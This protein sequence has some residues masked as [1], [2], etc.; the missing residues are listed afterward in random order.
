MP[1]RVALDGLR[2]LAERRHRDPARVL[3]EATELLARADDPGVEATLW[4]VK[5][6][7]LQELGRPNEAVASFRRS[8]GIDVGP[9]LEEGTALARASLAVSLLSV[10]ETAAA[11]REISRARAAAPPSVQWVVEMLHGLVLQRTGRLDA[12]L[13]TYRRSLPGLLAEGHLPYVARLLLNR[14]ALLA[15][16]GELEDALDD[17]TEAERISTE[18]GLPI[19]AAMAAHNGAFA[20]VRRGDLPDALAAFDRAERAYAVL[21]NPRYQ[22]AV[23]HADRCEALLVAGLVSEAR[24]AAT[25]AVRALE[26]TGDVANLTESRLLLARALLADGAYAEAITEATMAAR[27]FQASR[28]L[29]WAAQA[30]YVALQAEALASE[31]QRVPP[32][33]LLRRSRRIASELE[34]QGWPVEALHVRT[35]VGRIALALGRPT[36]ARAELA[37]A[38][39]ART[40]GTADLR[41]QAW[42]ATALLRVA[43]GNV[44]AAKRALNRGMAVVDEY[45]ASLGA[46]ELRAHAAGHGADLARLGLRLALDGGRAAEVL[47]WAERWRA[48]ALRHPAVHPPDDEKLA[49]DLAELRRDRKSVV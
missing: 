47:R 32:P 39:A 38:A 16:Q 15:Y 1:S 31:D 20:H 29:P 37:Q 44:A 24:A 22:V 10:G 17:L 40:K 48:G 11:D 28:R 6:L 21:N 14:G 4:W 45:R 7:A 43:D 2:Q 49:S 36:V 26:P 13:A 27:Q 8:V 18:Q 33:D 19:L 9:G 34:Q 5:G 42:H 25:A 23:L 46:T 12:A 30:R 3:S 41:A 35:F